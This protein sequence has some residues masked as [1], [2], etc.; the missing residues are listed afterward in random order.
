MGLCGLRA[1]RRGRHLP[2]GQDPAH[3]RPC[4]RQG[5]GERRLPPDRAVQ[6]QRGEWIDIDTVADLQDEP[7]TTL[8]VKE[9][10]ARLVTNEA[11]DRQGQ[12][13]FRRER[14]LTSVDE[15]Q[16][17]GADG[18]LGARDES[19]RRASHSRQR[20][21]ARSR[22]AHRS[23]VWSARTRASAMTGV[24]SAKALMTCSARAAGPAALLRSCRPWARAPL[25]SARRRPRV[26]RC[27]PTRASRGPRARA[28]RAGRL[29]RV[30]R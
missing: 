27:D 16:P 11:W 13:P 3:L 19:L 10:H 18:G 26:G 25:P 6:G 23:T 24:N 7:V 4:H 15:H 28:A 8:V 12:A 29:R 1:H 2:R 17:T 14:C 21:S 5:P 30:R 22:S 9:A 20:L